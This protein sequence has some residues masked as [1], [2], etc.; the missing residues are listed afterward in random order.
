MIEEDSTPTKQTGRQAG[1]T[2]GEA[3]SFTSFRMTDGKDGC[4]NDEWERRDP[5]LRSG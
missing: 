2:K 4:G 3:R 1:I 5:S